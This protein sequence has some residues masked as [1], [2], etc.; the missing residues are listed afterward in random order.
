M[1]KS[2][3]GSDFFPL[4][5]TAALFAAPS[6]CGGVQRDAGPRR[7][8]HEGSRNEVATSEKLGETSA[9]SGDVHCSSFA[10]GVVGLDV[11]GKRLQTCNT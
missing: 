11:T 4:L 1:K 9:T 6:K 8:S 10:G 3:P 5:Q 2:L 7:L